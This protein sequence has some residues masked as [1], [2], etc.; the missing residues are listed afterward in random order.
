MQEIIGYFL[1]F[2]FVYYGFAKLFRTQFYEPMYQWIASPLGEASGFSITWS[3]FGASYPYAFFIGASQILCAILI[4][5]RKTR[6]LGA[7]ILLSIVGN[8]VVVNYAYNIPVLLNSSIF[9]IM[10]AYLVVCEF[11]RLKTFF[12]DRGALPAD[13]PP[14]WNANTEHRLGLLKGVLGVCIFG[15]SLWFYTSF[16]GASI[17]EDSP[18]A[19]IWD[20]QSLEV[21]GDQM[22]VKTQPKEWTQ[23]I[24]ERGL[25]GKYGSLRTGDN[26]TPMMYEV[27]SLAGRVTVMSLVNQG[28]LFEGYYKLESKN[29]LLLEGIRNGVKG[30]D[31]VK[32]QLKLNKL[33]NQS[34]LE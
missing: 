16:S 27:D 14:R 18:I 13:T 25:A 12:W 22:Y 24:F 33:T 5:F 11:D 30:R 26:G 8:I 34:I 23:L 4:L 29:Q 7:L 31:S 1:A 6:L 19:G 17:K 21:N 10:T 9:L 28:N 20:V 32:I 3:F 15:Y 2:I